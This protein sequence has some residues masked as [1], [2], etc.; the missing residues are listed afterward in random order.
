MLKNIVIDPV[1]NQITVD[2]T[3]LIAEAEARTHKSGPKTYVERLITGQT[4]LQ[5]NKNYWPE[6]KK[7]EVAALYASG[8]VSSDELERL[9]K[10]NK[11]AIRDWRAQDWW[12]ELLERVHASIDEQTVSKLTNIVDK[13]L[14]AV[15]DRIINGEYHVH[16]KTDRVTGEVKQTVTRKPVSMRDATVVASTVV[17]KRQLL[18]G[19]P[20]SRA[21]KVTVNA[22]LEQLALEFQRFAAS[23]TVEGTVIKD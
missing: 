11:A 23:K 21:E 8:V 17:D 16:T 18:R 7:M 6:E 5:K 4:R 13:A 14:D 19:K 3:A 12:P 10:V 20:T 15:Q 9:T 1:T 22:R 2:S